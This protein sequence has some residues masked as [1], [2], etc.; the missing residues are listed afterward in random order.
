MKKKDETGNVYGKWTVIALD[1]IERRAM[2]LCR[3]ECGRTGVVDGRNLRGGGSRQCRVC[4]LTTHGCAGQRRQ[5]PEYFAWRSMRRRCTDHSN[6]QWK[7]YGG[8]G[9]EV[10]ERWHK[11]ENFLAD[12]GRKPS[13]E[14]TLERINNDAGYSPENCKWATR[15][16][17]AA[18]RRKPQRKAKVT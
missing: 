9:I 13:R 5:T 16:E 17:Q 7:D 15:K 4:Q 1:R 2:W 18:N 10:C 8:R 6:P 11:F 14:F 3:C 12:M